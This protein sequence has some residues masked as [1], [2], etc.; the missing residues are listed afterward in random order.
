MDMTCSVLTVCDPILFTFAVCISA[1]VL[2][3]THAITHAGTNTSL[4][5]KT[6]FHTV[7]TIRLSTTNNRHI[8]PNNSTEFD[9]NI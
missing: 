3:N 5:C 4:L 8:I 2:S 6:W 1:K 7:W 9:I